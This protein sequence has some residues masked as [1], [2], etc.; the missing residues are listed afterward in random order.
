MALSLFNKFKEKEELISKYLLIISFAYFIIVLCCYFII[1][2]KVNLQQN[3]IATLK[4]D[5]SNYSADEQKMYEKDFSKYKKKIV[6][7]SMLVNSHN[8]SSNV[9]S[10]LEE[11]TI[12]SAW[13]YNFN[14]LEN[15]SELNLSGEAKDVESFS[16]QVGLLEKSVY[17]KSVSVLDSRVSDTGGVLFILKIS[18]DPKI[19]SYHSSPIV[20]NESK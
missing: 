8:V 13:F 4:K 20:L 5:S 11:K 9:F 15:T 1:L 2:F 10:F 3:Q 19:F 7:F 12:P 18:L 17:I 14:L 16:R 6:D